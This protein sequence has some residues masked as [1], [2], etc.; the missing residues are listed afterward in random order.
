M[1]RQATGHGERREA[2]ATARAHSSCAS[3]ST[4]GASTRRSTSAAAADAAA[5]AAGPSGPRRSSSRTRWRG[6]RGRLGATTRSK[7]AA[8][9]E[10]RRGADIP[11]VRVVLAGVEDR[12][13]PRRPPDRREHAERLPLASLATTCCRSSASTASTRST[14]S[15]AGASRRT[16]CARPP[17]SARRIEAGAD[18][19]RPRN[20][21]LRPLGPATIRK[22]DRLP[23]AI[24]DEAIEDG[25][26]RAQPRSRPAHAREGPEADPDVPGDGRARRAGRRR[27]PSRTLAGS[28][29]RPCRGAT[30]QA[31]AARWM[32]RQASERH[33]GGARPRQGDGHLPPA[34]SR[35]AGTGDVR[36]PSRDR[37]DA[38]RVGRP[39]QRAVRHPDP[40][41]APARRDRGALP[42]PGRQDAKPASARSRSAP[43]FARRSSRTST[44]CARAGYSTDPEAYLFPN[45]RGGRIESP[46]CGRDRR[47]GGR[48]RVP[49]LTAR[50]C[51][52]CRTR[53]RTR[54][55]APTSRSRCS[56]TASTCCGS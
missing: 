24:L 28:M 44:G 2:P 13:R 43:I 56:P 18:R 39:R 26:H 47:R 4:G 32:R 27:R 20:R 17:S 23:E 14:P 31:V 25:L 36:R 22:L 15:C 29:R 10:P 1:G 30:A 5:A 35:R 3:A 34:A 53:R 48:A 9:S 38:R 11:R 7:P 19:P 52:R 42:H 51:R 12:R 40:R 8:P 41:A 55:A 16:S 54:C 46:A 49:R 37:R 6:S 33:R 45:L 50:G 21:R